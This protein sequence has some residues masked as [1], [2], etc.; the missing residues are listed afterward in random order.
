[1]PRTSKTNSP[2]LGTNPITRAPRGVSDDWQT[3]EAA[4]QIG[5]SGAK[6][7]TA[8]INE[9]SERVSKSRRSGPDGRNMAG[10]MLKTRKASHGGAPGGNVGTT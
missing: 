1:M 10:R 3:T 9:S 8:P 6:R 4:F 2:S 7:Q 5:K